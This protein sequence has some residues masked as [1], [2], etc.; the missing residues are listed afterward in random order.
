MGTNAADLPVETGAKGVLEVLHNATFKDNG[1]F[2]N[3][4]VP[5][6]NTQ[7]GQNEYRGGKLPW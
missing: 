6:W 3:I 5:T 2:F 1:C 7:P 4:T